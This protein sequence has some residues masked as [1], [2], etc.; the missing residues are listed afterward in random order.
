METDNNYNGIREHNSLLGGRADGTRTTPTPERR[1]H[2]DALGVSPTSSYDE[3]KAAFFQL[4]RK[5]HPDKQLQQQQQQQQLQKLDKNDPSKE[6]EE[7]ENE[8]QRIQTAWNVLRHETQRK[9]YDVALQQQR[10]RM[11]AKRS[12]AIQL[13]RTD[14]EEAVDDEAPHERLW[15][16][17]CRC[18][19]EI[20]FSNG[21]SG[22]H[23]DKDKNEEKK[24]VWV[25]CPGCCFVYRVALG[26]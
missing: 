16:Y 21:S 12:G 24:E 8:W 14:L 17:D 22:D 25:D 13:H 3:I 9:L 6:K 20:C 18:G 7:E 1:T 4:A 11:A 19:Q 15:V 5:H 26:P 10:L 23:D 2:Y